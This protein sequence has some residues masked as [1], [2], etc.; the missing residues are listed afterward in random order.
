MQPPESQADYESR[1]NLA[2]ARIAALTENLE[3][4]KVDLNKGR[5]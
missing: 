4:G 1:L 3:A 2:D 5:I